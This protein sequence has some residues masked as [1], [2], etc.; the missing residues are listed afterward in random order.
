MGVLMGR[1][2][3]DAEKWAFIKQMLYLL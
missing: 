1:K 2:A 3:P